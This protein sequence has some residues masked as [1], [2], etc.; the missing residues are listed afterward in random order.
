MNKLEQLN[1][2]ELRAENRHLVERNNELVKVNKRHFDKIFDQM[3]EIAELKQQLNYSRSE[4]EALKEQCEA[5]QAGFEVQKAA[6]WR[7]FQ[8]LNK[9]PH[10]TIKWLAS[11][12]LIFLVWLFMCDVLRVVFNPSVTAVLHGSV[13]VLLLILL[14]VRWDEYQCWRKS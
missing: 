14:A 3:N 8:K 1:I 7:Y 5:Y 12:V 2:A 6:W 11:L 13:S 9:L 4:C 10:D